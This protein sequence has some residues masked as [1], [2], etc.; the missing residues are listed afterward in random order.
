MSSLE[1]EV[2]LCWRSL[3]L[4]YRLDPLTH[5]HSHL[6]RGKPGRYDRSKHKP[7]EV[8][9]H[10]PGNCTCYGMAFPIKVNELLSQ[11]RGQ[12]CHKISGGMTCH[13]T[14]MVPQQSEHSLVSST[15]LKSCSMDASIIA[16]WWHRDMAL[17]YVLHLGNKGQHWRR[18]KTSR[19]INHANTSSGSLRLTHLF[20][21][22]TWVL[23]LITC[24]RYPTWLFGVR[25]TAFCR[26]RK[27][28]PGASG[29]ADHER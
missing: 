13:W 29:T 5:S 25:Q 19:M 2:L 7:G 27:A 3:G 21:R 26:S 14:W 8:P 1:I 9:W 24:D 20:S 15:D 6:H 18:P 16:L 11:N 10:P 23:G 22:Y 28:D 4:I 12:Q 17:P